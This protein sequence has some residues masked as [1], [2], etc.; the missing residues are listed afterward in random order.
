LD[1]IWS[2]LEYIVGGWTWQILGAIRALVTVSEA[3]EFCF[4]STKQRTI[5]PIFPETV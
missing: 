2:T 3:G 1:E 5:S 4:L